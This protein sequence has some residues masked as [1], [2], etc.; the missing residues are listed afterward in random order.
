MEKQGV[1]RRLH[2]H[3]AIVDPLIGRKVQEMRLQKNLLQEEIAY[4]AGVSVGVISRF[5]QGHQSLSAERLRAIA[6]VLG[7]TCDVFLEG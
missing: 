2:R 3:R 4:Q 7:V 5:E 1:K 6:H